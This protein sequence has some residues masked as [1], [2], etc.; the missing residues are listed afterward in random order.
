M[1]EVAWSAGSEFRPRYRHYLHTAAC[2]LCFSQSTPLVTLDLNFTY[3][4][5]I[6]INEREFN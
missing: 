5:N 3:I 1:D 2:L 4:D 6:Y